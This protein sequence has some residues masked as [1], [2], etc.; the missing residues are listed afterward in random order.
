MYKFYTQVVFEEFKSQHLLT[1]KLRLQ[2]ELNEFKL[3]SVYTDQIKRAQ[4]IL[5]KYGVLTREYQ[6][7]NKKLKDN[8]ENIIRG[9]QEKRG[10]IIANFENHLKQIREQIRED[11]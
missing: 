7:Q 5:S 11:A 9:E 2:E 4:L 1:T 3:G 8:H 10:Q 6:S